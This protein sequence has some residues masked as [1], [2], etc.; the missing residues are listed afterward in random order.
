M[1]IRRCC[2]GLAALLLA[3]AALADWQSVAPGV[4]FQEFREEKYDIFV[5]RIDL[6]NDAI[7]VIASRQSEKGTKVSDFAKKVQA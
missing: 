3:S 2:I 5:T 7:R 4:D 1:I 6:T